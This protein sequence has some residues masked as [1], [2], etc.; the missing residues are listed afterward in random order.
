MDLFISGAIIFIIGAPAYHRHIQQRASDWFLI[1]CLCHWNVFDCKPESR[2]PTNAFSIVKNCCF[3]SNWQLINSLIV[4]GRLTAFVWLINEGYV[5]VK[6][7]E[8]QGRIKQEPGHEHNDLFS[9]SSSWCKTHPLD[10]ILRHT[11]ITCVDQH[12][13]ILSGI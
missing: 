1:K 5:A 9:P 13:I 11:H 8:D 7:V 3:D 12:D 6:S 10:T 4:L 2:N